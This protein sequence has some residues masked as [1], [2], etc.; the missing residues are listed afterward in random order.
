MNMI[1]C[2]LNFALLRSSLMCIQAMRSSNLKPLISN[3]PRV[4]FLVDYNNIIIV[5]IVING[6]NYF[7]IVTVNILKYIEFICIIIIV[8]V[9]YF[10]LSL[11][12]E[13]LLLLLL[14]L[15]DECKILWGEPDREYVFV[16]Y[17]YVSTCSCC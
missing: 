2:R 7:L 9:L 5:I 11:F 14:L 3:T 15:L 10:C 1:R 4:I 13:L 16:M 8:V 17:Y 12:Y 6:M